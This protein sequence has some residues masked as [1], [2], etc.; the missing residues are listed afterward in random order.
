MPDLTHVSFSFRVL[1]ALGRWNPA[2]DVT[3]MMYYLT[4]VATE[5]SAI[6]AYNKLHLGCWKWLVRT[7]RRQTFEPVGAYTKKQWAECGA[8]MHN[9]GITIDGERGSPGTPSR[10]VGWNS[11]CSGPNGK[12]C[13]CPPTCWTRCGPPPV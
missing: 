7:L 1:G 6:L 5:Q 9:L 4:G 13:A 10:S 3:P 11:S 2:Q 8:V 12:A